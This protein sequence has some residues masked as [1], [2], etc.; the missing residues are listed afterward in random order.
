MQ[1]KIVVLDIETAALQS[2]HWALFDQNISLDQVQHDWSILAF[3]A[4]RLGSKS[5]EY[6]DTG[7]RGIKHV[8]NDS[9]LLA[10]LWTILDEADIVVGQNVRRFDLK[11]INARLIQS[12]YGPYSPVRVIDTLEVARRQFAFTS[13]K[14]AWTSKYLTDEPKSA[15]KRF[16]G[17]DLWA[18]C[19]KD[20]KAAWAEMRRYN[21]RDVTATEKLYLK[22]RPWIVNHP[23]LGVYFKDTGVHKCPNCGSGNTQ[24]RGVAVT[25]AFKYPRFQCQSCGTWSKGKERIKE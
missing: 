16:P 4:K 1:P 2:Y 7:G 25:Q 19:L 6:M 22:M 12:G 5:T 11:K 21:I 18:E 13:N 9:R 24:R 10:R 14:L 3:C 20:N 23:K 15:H 17:F 8:R